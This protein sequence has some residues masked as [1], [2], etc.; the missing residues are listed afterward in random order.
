[1]KQYNQIKTKVSSFIENPKVEAL[2]AVLIVLSIVLLSIELFGLADKNTIKLA[3]VCGY[4]LNFIFVIELVLRG[5]VIGDFRK[6]FKYHLLDVF[7]VI[8]PLFQALSIMRVL[9]LARLVRIIKLVRLAK[10]VKLAKFMKIFRI[11]KLGT[12]VDRHTGV[13][14]NEG[15]P[16]E[17][18]GCSLDDYIKKQES[19]ILEFK[20]TL[21]GNT[22]DGKVNDVLQ[23]A[24]VKTVAAFLNSKGGVLLIGVEDNGEVCGIDKDFETLGKRKNEDG[25]QQTLTH[26]V[27][28]K[29]GNV[30]MRYMKI[31]FEKK[32]NKTV[33]IV[34]VKKSNEPCYYY[35]KKNDGDDFYVRTQNMT[36]SLNHKETYNY[37]VEHW[38]NK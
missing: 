8:P 12:V 15:F 20:A 16:L 22:E 24:V 17:L 25:F 1:M 32:E 18:E 23:K 33:C 34:E 38:K 13:I 29:L 14:R 7:A 27:V 3:I 30:I 6:F 21:R 35:E 2:I 28:G 9:R 5:Y 4:Y 11:H 19:D 36:K 10:F 26:I 37:I 31:R